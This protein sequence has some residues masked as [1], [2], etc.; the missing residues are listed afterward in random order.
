MFEFLSDHPILCLKE[1]VYIIYLII[2]FYLYKYSILSLIFQFRPYEIV[3]IVHDST[4]LPLKPSFERELCHFTSNRSMR[5][6]GRPW[7]RDRA[8]RRRN[9]PRPRKLSTQ[10]RLNNAM[11]KSSGESMRTISNSSRSVLPP[12][13]VYFKFQVNF[14]LG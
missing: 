11:L 14:G 9:A 2:R 10:R 5:A 8:G 6:V 13:F 12:P 3:H 1:T 4:V 7:P